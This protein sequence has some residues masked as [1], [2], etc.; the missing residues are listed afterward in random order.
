[1]SGYYKN[2][3]VAALLAI[4]FGSLGLHRFYLGQ[5]WGIFYLLF[6]WTG[7]PGAVGVIEGV[8]FIIG[9]ETDWDYHYNNPDNPVSAGPGIL[10]G[11]VIIAAVLSA[12]ML[13]FVMGF[14][15]GFSMLALTSHW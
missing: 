8:M 11:I 1:M 13:L 2:K 14:L 9:T 6:G 4:F 5:W 7:L 10:G 15:G 3:F 12:A